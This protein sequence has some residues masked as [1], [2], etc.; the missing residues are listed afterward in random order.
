MNATIYNLKLNTLDLIQ[1]RIIQIQSN[2]NN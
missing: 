2:S 1:L